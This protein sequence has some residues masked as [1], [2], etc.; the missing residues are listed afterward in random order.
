[1]KPLI[2]SLLSENARKPRRERKSELRNTSKHL[3]KTDVA[4][5]EK[6]PDGSTRPIKGRYKNAY[7][8]FEDVRGNGSAFYVNHDFDYKYKLQKS[9][10]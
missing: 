4:D 9:Q 6:A 7:C 10:S 1:M 3:S 2:I 5:K 8:I